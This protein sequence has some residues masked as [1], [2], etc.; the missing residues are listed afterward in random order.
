MAN[1][2]KPSKRMLFTQRC[3]RGRGG[4]MCPLHNSHS[5]LLPPHERTMFFTTPPRHLLFATPTANSSSPSIGPLRLLCTL[6]RDS[7][8]WLR[9]TGR[10]TACVKRMDL[11]YEF[12]D[13]FLSR[14]P[15]VQRTGH[16]TCGSERL[17]ERLLLNW[18]QG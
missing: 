9:A 14:S 1:G 15:S 12:P 8:N 3:S 16:F 18:R 2:A 5:R 4:S 11:A 10:V 6:T 13:N 17:R 7:E